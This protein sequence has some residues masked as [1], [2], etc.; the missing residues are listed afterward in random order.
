ASSPS[1]WRSSSWTGCAGMRST[2]SSCKPSSDD[3]PGADPQPEDDLSL[4]RGGDGHRRTLHRCQ[5][6]L[7]ISR[8]AL[9]QCRFCNR[10]APKEAE[11]CP[12]CLSSK[13]DGPRAT[14]PI[15]S[16]TPETIWTFASQGVPPARTPSWEEWTAACARLGRDAPTTLLEILRTGEPSQQ[17]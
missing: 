15:A 7:P 1:V 10:L 9:T 12:G 8:E 13:F 3:E 16:E 2:N 6:R 17:E 11:W 4:L 14:I 5:E